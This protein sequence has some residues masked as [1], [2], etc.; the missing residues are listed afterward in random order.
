[1]TSVVVT[2]RG[3][4]SSVAEGADAFFDALIQRRSGILDGLAPCADFDPEQ[5]L[6]RDE[7]RL[8]GAE[9]AYRAR[10]V[11]RIAEAAE[12]RVR[13]HRVPCLFRDRVRQP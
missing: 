7:R 6:A 1:M 5:Y 2:G 8:V 9:E 10:D 13:K 4:V 3:V 12:R 11:L